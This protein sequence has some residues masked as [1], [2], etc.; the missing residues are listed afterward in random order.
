ME[1]IFPKTAL[2]IVI[3]RHKNSVKAVVLFVRNFRKG[4]YRDHKVAHPRENIMAPPGTAESWPTELFTLILFCLGAQTY[5]LKVIHF[6]TQIGSQSSIW[7]M[8]TQ[9]KLDIT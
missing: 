3:W 9:I 6:S 4:R 1:A 2:K 8:T 5:Y 7:K